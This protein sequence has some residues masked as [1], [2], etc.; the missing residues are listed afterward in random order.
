MDG[1]TTSAPTAGYAPAA[2]APA[3]GSE[4]ALRAGHARDVRPEDT[5]GSAD[6]P[7]SGAAKEPSPVCAGLSAVSPRAPRE[8][9]GPPSAPVSHVFASLVPAAPVAVL[10]VPGTASAAP[11]GADTAA[12]SARS[13]AGTVAS[14]CAWDEAA[15]APSGWWTGVPGPGPRVGADRQHAPQPVPPPGPGVLAPRPFALPVAP[16]L[17]GGAYEAALF[18][19]GRVRAALPGMRG[20]PG[21][22]AGQPA[23]HRS[24]STDPSYRLR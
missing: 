19:P 8:R 12:G 1:P 21:T 11:V 3:R 2:H 15:S 13:R 23:P 17:R 7:L 24:C 18:V 10:P 14:A 16:V 22:K 6:A 5:D 20:P 4:R 9:R